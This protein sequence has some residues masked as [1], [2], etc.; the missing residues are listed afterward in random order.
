MFLYRLL[1]NNADLIFF[2][3]L[4]I[5]VVSM[6]LSRFGLSFGQFSILGIWII[7]GRFKEKLKALFSDKAA[8][9]LISF[10]LMHVLGL[11]YTDDMQWALK[12]LR[13]KLPL[14]FLPIVFA[15]S[16][17]LGRVR[18]NQLLMLYFAA[19]VVASLIS[20]GVF[21]FTEVNDFRE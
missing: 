13:V 4:M 5:V 2:I 15:T 10:Y 14:L 9:V 20:L 21:L 1:K 18:T 17:P 8:L 12:D 7:E 6:P 16:K 19:V 3:S 11:L